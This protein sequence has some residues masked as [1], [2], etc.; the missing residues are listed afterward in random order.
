MTRDELRDYLARK[1]N[2]SP[3]DM[4]LADEAMLAI[5][6]YMKFDRERLAREIKK[7][8]NEPVDLTEHGKG[9][10]NGLRT[11]AQIVRQDGVR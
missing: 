4:H 8:I 9:W 1:M 2:L 3:Q 11:A 7:P 5:D 10:R 6:L